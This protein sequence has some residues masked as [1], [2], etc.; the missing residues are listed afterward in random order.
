MVSFFAGIEFFRF[1]L[2]TMH[3]TDSKEFQS[4]SVPFLMVAGSSC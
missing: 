4:I 2:K 3:Y 1:W